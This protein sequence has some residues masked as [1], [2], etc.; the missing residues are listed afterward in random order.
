MGLSSDVW[1]A[2]D[3]LFPGAAYLEKRKRGRGERRKREGRTSRGKRKGTEDS[4][5][6]GQPPAGCRCSCLSPPWHPPTRARLLA[7]NYLHGIFNTLV[8]A[9]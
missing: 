5:E 2:P 3:S 1:R 8:F 9:M 4:R 7:M 6:S